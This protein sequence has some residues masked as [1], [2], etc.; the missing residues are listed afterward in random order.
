MRPVADDA[1]E[2]ALVAHSPVNV[3]V[4]ASEADDRMTLARVIHDGISHRAGRFVGVFLGTQQQVRADDVDEWFAQAAG[5]TLFIDRV[6]HLSP[7]AQDR[8]VRLLTEQLHR[9]NRATIPDGADWVRVIAGSDRSLRA[10]VGVGA[11]SDVLF[12]RLNV[13]HI[14]QLHQHE[15]EKSYEST[16]HHV[17]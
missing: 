3:M 13:I 9:A 15:T 7:Q 8:L 2:L 11:F 10:D 17:D 1:T 12:Y 16:G 6:G 4:T 5:G 14:V